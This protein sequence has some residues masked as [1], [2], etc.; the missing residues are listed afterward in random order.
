MTRKKER[1]GDREYDEL[2]Q[3]EDR[4]KEEIDNQVQHS[5]KVTVEVKG[6]KFN[7]ELKPQCWVKGIH[8][9]GL[10]AQYRVKGK[11]QDKR[12]L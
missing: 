11:V 6:I 5:G 2:D 4:I 1:Q 7:V 3:D 9:T 10:M 12:T 8:S